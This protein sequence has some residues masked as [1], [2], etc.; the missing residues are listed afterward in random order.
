MGLI[1]YIKSLGIVHETT[2][3]YL[4]ASNDVVERKNRTLINLINAIMVNAS[5]PKNFWG[6]A[7]LTANYKMNRVPRKQT[8]LTPYEL[9]NKR[10]P[11]L[12]YF[13]VWGCLAYVRLA[14]PK[15]PKLGV[16]A[17]KCAFVGYALTSKAYR[18]Y[19]IESNIIIES[20]DAI[21][22]EDKFPFKL[23]N[24]GGEKEKIINETSSTLLKNFETNENLRRSK[25]AKVEKDF[26][27]DYLVYS[28]DGDP[29]TIEEAL[30]SPNSIFWKE[31]INEEMESLLSNKTWKLVDLP[32]GCKTIG[33]KW[34]LRRKLKLDGTIDKYKVRL[35]AKGFKLKENV[36]FFYT[37]SPVTKV[38]SIRLFIAIAA[39]HNLKI[40][41]MD[42]KITFLNGDLEEEIYMDQPQGFVQPCHENKVCKLT[43]SL[44]GLKQALK[45][46]HE[47]FDRSIV[48][49]DPCLLI[50]TKQMDSTNIFSKK[51]FQPSSKL[52]QRT[53]AFERR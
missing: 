42:V 46:W 30:N 17:R 1:D 11:N 23:R 8:L 24:S 13:R 25:R 32:I 45:Q 3:P 22:H 33:C 40:H 10:K 36:D 41:Q 47:K 51:S 37:Y 21:F 27:P 19:D 39:I 6:E 20:L 31:A 16:R 2:L 53:K 35:V 49:L 5:A 28:V 43:K 38:T 18:F 4:P 9:W 14:D 52:I 7:I 26:G 50:F 12:N 48:D 34:V 44:Y 29:K 15:I